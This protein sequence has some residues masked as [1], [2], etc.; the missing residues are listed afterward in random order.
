MLAMHAGQQEST[1][2]CWASVLIASLGSLPHRRRRCTWWSLSKN[3]SESVLS[4]VAQH[5]CANIQFKSVLRL[6]N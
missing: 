3:A 1:S 2:I 4:K 6:P 5:V